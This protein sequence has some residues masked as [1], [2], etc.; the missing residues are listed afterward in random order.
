MQ[1]TDLSPCFGGSF[2]YGGTRPDAVVSDVLKKLSRTI[3][4]CRVENQVTEK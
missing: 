2:V 4:P 3:F 1:L